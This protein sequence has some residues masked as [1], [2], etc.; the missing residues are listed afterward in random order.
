MMYRKI[1]F[2]TVLF[3]LTNI[4][5]LAQREH[6]MGCVYDSETD[7]KVSQ[8]PQL[9]TR[10]YADLPRKYSLKKYAPIPKGQGGYGTCTSWATTYAARTIAEAINNEW[11][12]TDSITKEA[13]API[14]I[15]KQ[16][17]PYGECQEGSSVAKS[18]Q[19]LKEKGAP[20]LKSFSVLCADYIPDSLY[21]EAAKYRIED[22][23]SL[24]NDYKD[25]GNKILL[26]KKALAEGHPVVMAINCYNSFDVIY[27]SDI[28]NGLQDSLIGG[29]AMCVVG[30]DDDKYGGAF[31][32]M[33]SW[34][35]YWANSGYVWVKYDDYSKNVKYAYD[36]YVKRKEN[37][38]PIPVPIQKKYTISGQM[39]LAILQGSA[40]LPVLYSET[41][42]MPHYI[43]TEELLSGSKFGLYVNNKEPA[44]VYAI[45]SD[46]QNN[47][48]KLFP[49]ADNISAYM[50]YLQNN[51]YLPGEEH[52]FKLDMTAGTDYFCVLFAKEELDINSIVAQLKNEEGTIYQKLSKVLGNKLVSQNEIQYDRSSISFN[53]KSD[54]TVVPLVIEIAHKDINVKY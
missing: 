17:Q 25:S 28:W 1:L 36:V 45:A 44:W 41:N 22:Y 49:Y 26:T 9:L 50:N 53:A 8:R 47:V 11:D 42:G 15:Y 3:C 23:T 2:T 21:A 27:K 32:I 35:I 16:V 20:K 4:A 14:F 38:Q 12:N 52:E 7:G 6:G 5:V 37:P 19:L 34:G 33:N 18:L 30:Y 31:E 51:I 10:E 39:A 54:N 24:F 29:H 13:F 46:L 48:S 40:V 43:P